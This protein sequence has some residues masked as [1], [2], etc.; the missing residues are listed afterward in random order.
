M[1]GVIERIYA[2]RNRRDM[3]YFVNS[4]EDRHAR[5]RESRSECGEKEEEKCGE[6]K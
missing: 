1:K 6:R 3:P 5:N 2:Y 4:P